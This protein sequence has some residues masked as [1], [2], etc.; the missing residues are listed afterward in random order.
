MKEQR[1]SAMLH[2]VTMA[3]HKTNLPPSFLAVLLAKR[4]KE[5]LKK[6]DM[7]NANC[8]LILSFVPDIEPVKLEK[9]IAALED[10][11]GSNASGLNQWLKARL[12]KPES[13]KATPTAEINK[14]AL[15]KEF[16]LETKP[17]AEPPAKT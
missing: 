1:N 2:S 13:V 16:S 12:D 5:T 6:T 17:A 8:A 15:L 4:A 9:M 3:D 11:N 10:L 14:D 7:F